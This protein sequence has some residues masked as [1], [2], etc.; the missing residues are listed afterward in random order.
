MSTLWNILPVSSVKSPCRPGL[1]WFHKGR[2]EKKMSVSVQARICVSIARQ[3]TAEALAAAR[4]VAAAADV[5]E[6]RLDA[7][8]DADPSPFLQ[9]IDKPLLFTNRPLWEG[10]A[11]AGSEE[12]RIAPLAKA[13]DAGAAYVDIELQTAEAVRDPLIARARNSGTEA[14][15]SWHD[16]KTTPSKQALTQIL[17][18]QYRSGA[19]I[20]KIVTTARSFLDVLPVLDLQTLASEMG[21]PLIAFCMGRAG[22]ISRVATLELGGYMT[23]VAPDAGARTAPG[24][25]PLAAMRAIRQSINNAV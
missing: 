11:F 24:Q 12:E 17:Q 8:S 16:F 20:G 18:R 13:I 23:Y 25:L 5:I 22:M 6:I 15:V 7:L 1:L 9:A 3:T 4:D 19:P 21:F 10:G 14:I 2:A